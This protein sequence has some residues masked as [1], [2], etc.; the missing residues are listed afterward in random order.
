MTQFLP[1]QGQLI[2]FAIAFCLVVGAIVGLRSALDFVVRLDARIPI[3]DP[4][5]PPTPNERVVFEKIL[6][7]RGWCGVLLAVVV[8]QTSR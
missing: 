1:D 5:V 3:V 2:A 8:G 6:R 4:N 7:R